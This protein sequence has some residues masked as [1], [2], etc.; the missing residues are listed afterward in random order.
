MPVDISAMPAPSRPTRPVIW[1]SLVLRSTVATRTVHLL[2]SRACGGVLLSTSPAGCHCRPEA[3][4]CS[5]CRHSR[6]GLHHKLPGTSE[7]KDRTSE[8][9]HGPF[10]QDRVAR[11]DD[12]LSAQRRSGG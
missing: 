10:P 3:A 1:V 6:S 12:P 4:S 7:P 8:E 5:A 11:Y 9:T 2:Q